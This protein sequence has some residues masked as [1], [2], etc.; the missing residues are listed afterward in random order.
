MEIVARSS[1]ARDRAPAQDLALL[2]GLGFLLLGLA[3]FIP[4]ITTHY[5]SLSFAGHRSGAKLFGVFQTSV[6]QNLLHLAFGLGGVALSRARKTARGF[7]VF[8]GIVYLVVFVYGIATPNGS[9]A[10]FVP[11]D[12]ADDVLHLALGL[13]MVSFGLLPEEL[14]ARSTETL[15]GFLAA[16]AIFLAATGVAYRPLRLIPFAILLALIAV[17]MG[18]RS[19]RLAT[20]AMIFSG[21]CFVLGMA[22]AVVTSHPLW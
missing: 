1:A 6:L 5:G 19:L 12:G 7:L 17:G 20:A 18:G 15:A 16:A 11:L 3:G 4:G 2:V 21:V 10:N 14:P 9:G 13:G 8:G 22:A